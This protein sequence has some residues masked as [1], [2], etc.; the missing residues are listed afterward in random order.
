MENTLMREILLDLLKA[1]APP[2]TPADKEAPILELV[3]RLRNGYN[4]VQT[5]LIYERMMRLSAYEILDRLAAS[6]SPIQTDKKPRIDQYSAM[7]DQVTAAL[8]EARSQ[9][10]SGS[11]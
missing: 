4:T 11:A 3:D 5:A 6:V 2:V 10:L 1:I 7:V 8:A 9:V